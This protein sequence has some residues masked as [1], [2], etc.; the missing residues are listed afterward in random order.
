MRVLHVAS[1]KGNIG[2]Q[3][4]HLGFRSWFVSLV[5]QD[6]EWIEVEIR[7]V[8]RGFHTLFD[9]LKTLADGAD[10][11]VI[12][13]GN[14][15]ELWPENSSTGTSI[16]LSLEQLL[17]LDIP[18]FFNALG[19]DAAQ[20]I[21][22]NALSFLNYLR[23][24][25]QHPN[26][27]VTL[28]NDGAKAGLRKHF[29]SDDG[30]LELPDHG[31][32]AKAHLMTAESSRQNLVAVNL[33]S[34]MAQIRFSS[35]SY[36]ATTKNIIESLTVDSQLSNIVFVPHV[37]Q[38]IQT[39]L[40]AVQGSSDKLRRERISIA[41]LNTYSESVLDMFKPYDI[42]RL[43]IANRFHANVY[44]IATGA[45]L[46]PLV[47][48]PQVSFLLSGLPVPWPFDILE[49]DNFAFWKDI[50]AKNLTENISAIRMEY[51]REVSEKLS[52]QR[53]E[54]GVLLLEWLERNGVLN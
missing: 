38:D 42:S 10:L 6:I 40:D 43:V 27:F 13:G 51:A 22:P 16:D 54:V 20:G 14:F 48:Y 36:E 2:D 23:E 25:N 4:N 47:N 19:V 37:I 41:A 29:G 17:D 28:R 34:D 15:W 5:G 8:Y 35:Q 32:F 3:L 53:L 26:F 49:P 7:D 21:S 12:G 39:A 45:N 33:A 50:I 18:C 30:V 24:L 46:L 52:Q 9:R 11:V 1:F 44:S 31:F